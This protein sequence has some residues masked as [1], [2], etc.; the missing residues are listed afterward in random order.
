MCEDIKEGSVVFRFIDSFLS[1]IRILVCFPLQVNM[2]QIIHNT[3]KFVL[4]VLLNL[5][6]LKCN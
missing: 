3:T 1:C 5:C 6:K 4:C 2:I